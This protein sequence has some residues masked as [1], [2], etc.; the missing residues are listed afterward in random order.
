MH[1]VN[2]LS[3]SREY[4]ELVNERVALCHCRE[5]YISEDE[6]HGIIRRAWK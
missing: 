2:V 1:L 3:H 6:W 4:P 5:L